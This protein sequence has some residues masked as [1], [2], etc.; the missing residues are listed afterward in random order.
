MLSLFLDSSRRNSVTLDSESAAD[1][2][3]S[4]K[5]QRLQTK[6]KKF[7]KEIKKLQDEVIK[8]FVICIW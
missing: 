4:E 2:G 7:R 5:V 6:L 8:M 3:A 1:P